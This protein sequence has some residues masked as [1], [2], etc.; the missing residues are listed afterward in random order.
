M[1][2]PTR[3]Q[4]HTDRS[5]S[6]PKISG[7]AASFSARLVMH[8]PIAPSISSDKVTITHTSINSDAACEVIIANPESPYIQPT[9]TDIIE[10]DRKDPELDND[11]FAMGL[12]LS[13]T[14]S[15]ALPILSNQ[16]HLPPNTS[17]TVEDRLLQCYGDGMFWLGHVLKYV[18]IATAFE[19]CVD[20]YG[21]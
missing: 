17:Q 10:S 6:P 21:F 2:L 16:S 1:S 18:L 11:N 19:I 7:M 20:C 3:T 5:P 4:R 8:T 15:H 12:L 9:S 14:R 13:P